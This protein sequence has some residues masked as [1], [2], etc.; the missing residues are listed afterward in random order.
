MGVR[1]IK[2]KRRSSKSRAVFGVEGNFGL[3]EVGPEL[4]ELTETIEN[5]G[6]EC[7]EVMY[8]LSIHENYVSIKNDWGWG[9]GLLGYGIRPIGKKAWVLPVV[10]EDRAL[11]WSNKCLAV[12]TSEL[13]LTGW[14]LQLWEV[15]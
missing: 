6:K 11:R 7:C 4:P 9:L 15:T 14:T 8:V 13:S 12:R 2:E 10:A 5:C 1:R 3:D